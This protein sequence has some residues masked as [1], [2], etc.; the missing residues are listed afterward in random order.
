MQSPREFLYHIVITIADK[1]D[2]TRRQGGKNGRARKAPKDPR[3]K[4]TVFLHHERK[5]NI[6]GSS[7]GGWNRHYTCLYESD[8]RLINSAQIAGNIDK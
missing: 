2:T 7:T 5:R 3:K 1:I 8:G 6:Y 4:K